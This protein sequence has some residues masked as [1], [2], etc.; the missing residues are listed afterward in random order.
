MTRAFA[1]LLATAILAGCTARGAYATVQTT[2]RS[3]AACEAEQNADD[4]ARCEAEFRKSY[5]QYE[6]ERREVLGQKE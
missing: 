4:A 1:L 5:D 2:G 6:R 3:H